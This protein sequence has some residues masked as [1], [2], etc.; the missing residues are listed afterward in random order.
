MRN[1]TRSDRANVR[2][3]YQA[4]R[5]HVDEDGNVHVLT[6]RSRGDGGKRPWWMVAGRIEEIVREIDRSKIGGAL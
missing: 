3:R 4:S 1:L 2:E 6:S 5:V